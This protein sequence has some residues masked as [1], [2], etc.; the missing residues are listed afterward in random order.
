MAGAITTAPTSPTTTETTTDTTGTTGTPKTANTSS[1]QPSW[2]FGSDNMA[3]AHPDVCK[4]LCDL[5]GYAAAYGGDD[6]T[7]KANEELRKELKVCTSTLNH[8]IFHCTIIIFVHS[9]IPSAKS[10]M[11][12]LVLPRT[13]F[14][15]LRWLPLEPQ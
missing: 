12:L 13:F 8:T 4:K 5:S 2:A 11:C 3:P 10:D 6:V 1:A 15:S 14:P 7:A 9:W